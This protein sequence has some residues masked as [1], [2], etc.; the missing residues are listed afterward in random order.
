M[1]LFKKMRRDLVPKNKIGK[2][3]LY[4]IGE[5]FIVVIGIFLAF[6]LN[7]NKENIANSRTEINYL[8]GI[9][10]DLDQD[11]YN[12]NQLALFDADQLAAFTTIQ[13]ALSDRIPNDERAIVKAIARANLFAYFDGNNIVF[14]DMKSS[15]KVTLI[16]SNKL[17][18]SILKY[19][20]ASAAETR[21]QVDQLRRRHTSLVSDAFEANL[22]LNSM[23]EA[24]Y[25]NETE[26]TELT[27]LDLSFFDQDPNSKPAQ[28]FSN[29]LSI[30][31]S[32]RLRINPF[33]PLS[34]LSNKARI[35]KP[36]AK[37]KHL[38]CM[39]LNTVN[40]I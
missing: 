17:R 39:L 38:S 34:I 28:V 5:I 35:S 22:D 40:L 1:L 21:N 16:S 23:I 7:I 32:L 26:N 37:R 29:Q 25:F 4:A 13:R 36:F 8:N 6:Q 14:E 33:L 2:Y 31:S 18:L 9:L 20:K 19:H 10:V 24:N 11:I 27:P 12:L 15:G 30:F 3:T